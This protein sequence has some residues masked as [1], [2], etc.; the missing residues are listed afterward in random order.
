MLL[1]EGLSLLEYQRNNVVFNAHHDVENVYVKAMKELK[2]FGFD[3]V[4]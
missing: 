4:I 2:I 1:K 3:E